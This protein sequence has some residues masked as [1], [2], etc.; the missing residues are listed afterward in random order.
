MNVVQRSAERV[1]QA[2][3]LCAEHATL[4]EYFMDR[5]VFNRWPNIWHRLRMRLWPNDL[6]L[7]SANLLKSGQLSKNGEQQQDV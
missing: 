6:D 7:R 1:Q 3:N 5:L 2:W 4:A